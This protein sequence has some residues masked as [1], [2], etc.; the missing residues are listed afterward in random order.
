[1]HCVAVVRHDAAYA[2]LHVHQPAVA[3]GEKQQA[4]LARAIVRKRYL[5]QRQSRV[6][7]TTTYHTR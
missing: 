4:A 6:K 7:S 3:A 5:Q 2:P 1:V